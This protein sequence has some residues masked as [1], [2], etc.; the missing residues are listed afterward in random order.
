M[1]YFGSNQLTEPFST[2]SKS[3]SICFL[4]FF[5]SDCKALPGL[6][7]GQRFLALIIVPFFHSPHKVVVIVFV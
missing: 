4:S 1:T 7:P 5:L 3:P 2:L 6:F